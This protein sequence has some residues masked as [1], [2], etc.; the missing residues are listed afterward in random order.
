MTII[1]TS[2][3]LSIISYDTYLQTNPAK[4]IPMILHLLKR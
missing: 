2:N 1:V 3:K 4:Q